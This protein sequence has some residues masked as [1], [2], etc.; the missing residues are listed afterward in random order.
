M[1]C[2]LHL[3][4]SA[5]TREP[6]NGEQDGKQYYFLTREKF[7]AMIEAGEM[8]EHACYCGNYYGTPKAA[9]EQKL[10]A[11]IDVI[12]EIEVQGAEQIKK[13]R[14][15]C[16]TVFI[17]PPSPEE[18]ER[19]LR[20]RGTES[21]EVI[22]KRLETA[23][24]ELACAGQYEYIVVNDSVKAAAQRLDGIITAEKCRASRVLD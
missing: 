6:R 16:V 22:N 23:H 11:G 14:P 17:A 13:T 10:N 5:T 2:G 15:D 4:V 9:V 18:L 1:R 19:R 8:L 12:L 24:R 20:G 3:S 21:D 7:E